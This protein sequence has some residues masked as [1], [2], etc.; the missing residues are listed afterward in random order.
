MKLLE[1]AKNTYDDL[2]LD[3]ILEMIINYINNQKKEELDLIFNE[4]FAIVLKS[5][6][7]YSLNR[8]KIDLLTKV[9]LIIGLI[10]SEKNLPIINEFDFVKETCKFDMNFLFTNQE[11]LNTFSFTLGKLSYNNPKTT[12]SIFETGI[13]YK[14]NDHIIPNISDLK[15]INFSFFE[16]IS[17]LYRN[18]LVNNFTIISKFTEKNP[19]TKQN[20]KLTYDKDICSFILFILEKMDESKNDN[21]N[22][23]IFNLCEALDKITMDDSAIEELSNTNYCNILMNLLGNKQNEGE[24]IIFILNNFN[25]FFQKE[26][27]NNLISLNFEKILQILRGLQKKYYLNSDILMLINSICSR[28]F[29][30]LNKDKDKPIKE[31]LFNIIVESLNIQDWNIPLILT[32]LRLILEILKNKDYKYLVDLIYDDFINTFLGVIR[33]NQNNSEILN[34]SYK[35]LSLFGQNN[36]YGYSMI[37][38]GLLDLIQE[39]FTKINTKTSEKISNSENELKETLFNLLARLSNDKNSVKKISDSLTENLVLELTQENP[40]SPSGS[41]KHILKLF[42]NITS[43]PNTVESFLQ[44]NGLVNILKFLKEDPLNIEN[45]LNALHILSN[46]SNNG[47]NYKKI[48]REAKTI[49]VISTNIDKTKHISKE[50]G[51]LGSTIIHDL[52]DSVAMNLLQAVDIVR[53]EVKKN[54]SSI[55]AEIKN[56]LINGKIV[57]M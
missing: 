44:Q 37:N 41:V 50:I 7:V 21:G 16:N 36:I 55:K 26:I 5:Y 13:I 43:Y 31:N 19:G 57:N 25:N 6:K 15:K 40:S 24:I 49:D 12:R 56:F 51:L 27:G 9:I 48:L 33:N 54:N 32:T 34:I 1:L 29:Y 39:S 20:I 2:I 14:I 3:S 53:N 18:L 46:I 45:D 35:I 17:G 42:K 8:E 47:D 30:N 22:I 11:F 10:S 52:N 23:T 28:L 38:E 4:I